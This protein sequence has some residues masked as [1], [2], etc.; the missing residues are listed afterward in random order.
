[1]HREQVVE[2]NRYPV[3]AGEWI[4]V[5]P[6]LVSCECDGNLRIEDIESHS[7]RMV[8]R[9]LELLGIGDVDIRLYQHVD[10]VL[11]MVI[12]CRSVGLDREHVNA[13]MFGEATS[14]NTVAALFHS[15]DSQS[16]SIRNGF[17][18]KVV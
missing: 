9:V 17:R 1:M 2:L 16:E 10:M 7:Q 3:G 4:G 14:R 12:R 8:I 5:G 11:G 6:R 15:L 13:G 18:F